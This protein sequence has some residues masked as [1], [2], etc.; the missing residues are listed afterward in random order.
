MPNTYSEKEYITALYKCYN[1]VY[2]ND[3]QHPAPKPYHYSAT[4]RA[5][6]MS[7]QKWLRHRIKEIFRTINK[8]RES[9]GL[10]LV[11]PYQSSLEDCFSGL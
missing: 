10:E 3:I 5:D 6:G 1:D 4:V 11:V 8:I 9:H 7:L 2:L